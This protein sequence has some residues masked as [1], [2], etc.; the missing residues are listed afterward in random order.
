MNKLLQHIMNAGDVSDKF[1]PFLEQYQMKGEVLINPLNRPVYDN[2]PNPAAL[3]AKAEMDIK[4]KQQAAYKAMMEKQGTIKQAEPE[5]SGKS[6]AWAIMTNPMTALSYKVKGQDIPENFERGERNNLDVPFDVL[7]PFFYVNSA[8]NFGEGLG[9]VATNPMSIGSEAPG[10]V[11]NALGAVPLVGEAAMLAREYVP[12]AK[13]AGKTF[14]LTHDLPLGTRIK[15]AINA[16]TLELEHPGDVPGHGYFNMTPDEVKAT[17]NKEMVELPKGAYSVDKNMSKNSAP[18]FWTQAARPKGD[19]TFIRNGKT[20]SLNWSGTQ[21][22]RVA[23]AVPS[24]AQDYIPQIQEIRDAV[25]SRIDYLKKL[26]DP[27]Y[28]NEIARL[29]KEGVSSAI[30]GE[31]QDLAINAPFGKRLADEFMVNYKPVLDK[32][33]ELV[34]QR[35][36]L[37]FPNTA[38]EVSDWAP[39]V[40]I[41]KQPTIYAVKGNPVTDRLIPHFGNYVKDRIN[42]YYL[43]D[44]FRR[45]N[46]DGF[47]D[48]SR[49]RTHTPEELQRIDLE[50]TGEFDWIPEQKEGGPIVNPRGFMDGQPPRGSNWR[51][52]GSDITMHGIPYPV[53]AKPNKGKGTMMYPGENYFFPKADYVDE[54]PMMSSGGQHGGL[55]RWFAEKWVDVK[56]GKTCGRQEGENRAYPACR[57]S[58]RVSSQTP[59]TSSEMSPAEKAKFK[60]TK[61]SSQRIPYNHKRN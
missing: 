50:D 1:L 37:N 49:N 22:K 52:P 59:K 46:R 58:R 33:I 7:N 38:I 17:M 3:R 42:R 32:P 61:T 19:F 14:N 48:L 57:P 45:S 24:W 40:N 8:K 41:Y 21:G 18:L 15:N 11:M 44:M 2:I 53:F 31:L 20:Q 16:G 47:I 51:I 4:A 26:N 10:L 13:A 39:S 9:R 55:D 54:Y 43:G 34:N 36:G 56:T 23:E 25:N 35:T 5:R 30:V 28:K 27:K 60:R 6:K 29:E 12:V